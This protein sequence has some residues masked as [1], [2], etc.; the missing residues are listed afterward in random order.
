MTSKRYRPAKTNSIKFTLG[1]LGLIILFGCTIVGYTIAQNRVPT[2]SEPF[3]YV[4]Y[5]LEEMYGVPCDDLPAPL[6][7]YSEIIDDASGGGWYGVYYSGEPYI[8]VDPHLEDE[9]KAQVVLHEIGHYVIYELDLP[10]KGD[11]CEGEAV[12]RE[13]SGGTWDEWDKASYGCNTDEYY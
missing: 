9:F 3:E 4:C 8:F 5:K 13:I 6:I 11:T 12:V 1:L 10:P 7:I 2:K